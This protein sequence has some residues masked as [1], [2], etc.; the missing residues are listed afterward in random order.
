MRGLIAKK[1]GMTQV[2]DDGGLVVPVTIIEAGPCMVTQIKTVER[3]GYDSI[4]VGYGYKKDKHT[5][6][7]MKGHYKKASLSP[8][9]MLAEL[10]IL[11]EV[12][13]AVF[14]GEI[15][16]GIGVDWLEAETGRKMSRPGLKK[17]V[18]KTYGRR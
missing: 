9:N 10:Q 3:D 5:T 17:Y 16:L 18:D 1:L 14:H 11:K 2:F 15:S 7:P 6:N 8:K 12:S 13:E 4:Q